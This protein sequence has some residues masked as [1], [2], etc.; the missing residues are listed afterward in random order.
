MK[1]KVLGLVKSHTQSWTM[2]KI[3]KLTIFS[4][5][6][7]KRAM[8]KSRP[9]STRVKRC[10]LRQRLDMLL[11]RWYWK[12]TN[13]ALFCRVIEYHDICNLSFLGVGW[14]DS[15]VNDKDPHHNRSRPPKPRLIWWQ[16]CDKTQNWNLT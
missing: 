1:F 14:V 10:S 6:R 11:N 5:T 9:W 8:L 4:I 12:N 7:W 16:R 3:Q 15:R 13:K 2:L